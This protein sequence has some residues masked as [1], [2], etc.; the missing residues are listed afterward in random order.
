MPGLQASGTFVWAD[1]NG[2]LVLITGWRNDVRGLACRWSAPKQLSQ[3]ISVVL[4]SSGTDVS[5][6]YVTKPIHIIPALEQPVSIAQL[7]APLDLTFI[8]N[9]DDVLKDEWS[10]SVLTVPLVEGADTFTANTVIRLLYGDKPVYLRVLQV[11]IERQQLLA[12]PE[13]VN[14]YN[15]KGALHMCGMRANIFSLHHKH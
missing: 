13:R 5:H 9:P 14:F 3:G 12:R 4:A 1:G 15:W 10:D 7:K 2:C 6:G 11:D 8:D